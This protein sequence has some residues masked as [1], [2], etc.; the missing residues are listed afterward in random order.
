[1]KHLALVCCLGLAVAACDGEPDRRSPLPQPTPTAPAPP[2]PA[3]PPAPPPSPLPLPP[4]TQVISL[5]ERVK[6]KVS[7]G[8][9][10]NYAIAVP[11]DGTLIVH[12]TWADTGGGFTLRLKVNGAEISWQC[13]ELSPWPVEGRAQVLA[14]QQVWIAVAMGAGCWD[15]A[16]TGPVAETTGAEF[17]VTTS[18]E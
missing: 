6:D 11:A 9:D 7:S 13:G 18:M 1:L 16:R 10:K 2:E 15:Y 5:G 3:R 12:L 17:V 14:G 8:A 4:G